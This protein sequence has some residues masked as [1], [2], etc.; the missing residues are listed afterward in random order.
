MKNL[1]EQ[2]VMLSLQY[3]ANNKKEVKSYTLAVKMFQP[4]AMHKKM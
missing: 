3:I 2:L 4:K 1:I